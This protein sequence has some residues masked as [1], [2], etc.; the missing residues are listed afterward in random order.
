MEL[1]TRNKQGRYSAASK[2]F[3]LETAANYHADWLN[4]AKLSIR[5]P[6]D[7]KDF[8]V[9]ALIGRES[10]CFCCLWLDNRHRVIAFDILFNGTIDSTTV[11][12]REVARTAL[13]HN[14]AA[15]ILAHNHPSGVAEP[16]DA[17]RMITTRIQDAL[18]LLDIR[19]LDHF[20]IGSQDHVVSLASRGM[21]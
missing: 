11:Y 2:Q 10:E 5:S 4:S 8:L 7:S 13:K 19:L 3:I 20:V 12:P 15:V 14:A 6:A 16:S 9:K 21:L 17:D 1:F 18:G